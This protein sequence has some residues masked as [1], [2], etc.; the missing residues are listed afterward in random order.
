MKKKINQLFFTKLF[1]PLTV[2]KLKLLLIS[3]AMLQDFAEVSVW[4]SWCEQMETQ[5][6]SVNIKTNFI[7]DKWY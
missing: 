2:V 1:N 6:S 4:T 3:R 7:C 5:V